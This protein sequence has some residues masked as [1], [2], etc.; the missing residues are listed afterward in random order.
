MSHG[1]PRGRSKVLYKDMTPEALQAAYRDGKANQRSAQE[2]VAAATAR[3][4]PAA[5]MRS[6]QVARYWSQ[7]LLMMEAVARKRHI[8]L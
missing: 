2:D 5:N 3:G 1:I 8:P 6:A 7:E 4:I